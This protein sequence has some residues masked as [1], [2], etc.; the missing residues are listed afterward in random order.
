MVQLTRRSF[1]TVTGLTATSLGLPRLAKAQDPYETL[2]AGQFANRIRLLQQV[3]G[4]FLQRD[5]TLGS[6]PTDWMLQLGQYRGKINDKA[7]DWSGYW[8]FHPTARR[9]WQAA[10]GDLRYWNADGRAV[11]NPED[12]ELF[13][14]HRVNTADR[15]VRIKNTPTSGGWVSLV[16]SRFKCNGSGPAQAAVFVVQFL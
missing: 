4:Q 13:T 11:G 1:L 3:G 2:I 5:F 8:I 16:G 12:W 6:T 15:T 10:A 9:C 7:V 14:F